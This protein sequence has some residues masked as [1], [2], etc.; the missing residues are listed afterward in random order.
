MSA[1]ELSYAVWGLVLVV[2]LVV[3]Y[4]AVTRTDAAARP[5]AVLARMAVQPVLRV[6]LVLTFLWLGW[7]LFAR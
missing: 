6:C 1:S 4:V 3:S 2:G 7:H 5:E